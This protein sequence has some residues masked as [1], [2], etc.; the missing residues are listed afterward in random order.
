L[1]SLSLLFKHV[2][3]FHPLLFGFGRRRDHVA[4]RLAVLAPYLMFAASFLPYYRFWTGIRRQILEYRAIREDYGLWA[5]FPSLSTTAA[6]LLFVAAALLAAWRFRP[7]PISRSCLLV[8][9]VILI[10]LP[11]VVQYYFVWPIA[12]GALCGGGV[13]FFVYSSVVTLFM[14]GSP[15]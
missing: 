14:L 2:T 12:L 3:W 15:D 1:L 10:F 7:L 5:F 9:L 4:S 8:F 13:G 11:G 6:T